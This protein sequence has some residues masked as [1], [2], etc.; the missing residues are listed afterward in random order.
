[1]RRADSSSRCKA[2]WNHPTSGYRDRRIR[3][4][5]N[6]LDFTPIMILLLGR[7][8]TGE[9]HPGQSD[10]PFK[11]ADMLKVLRSNSPGSRNKQLKHDVV[12]RRGG[13]YD[14]AIQHYDA[15]DY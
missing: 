12:S 13:V 8:P 7:G 11:T 5:M 1:M 14:R 10:A 4:K 2:G 9:V 6:L 15:L 3:A